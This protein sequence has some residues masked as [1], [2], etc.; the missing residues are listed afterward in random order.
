MHTQIM[1]PSSLAGANVDWARDRAKLWNAAEHA[2]SRRT[3]RVAREFQVTL[4]AELSAEQRLDLARRFSQEL[5]DRYNIA[6]DLAIHAPRAGSD[7]RNFHAHL[8]GTTREVS[9]DGLGR[10]AGMDM[11]AQERLERG[12]MSGSQEF[13]AVRERWASLTNE[14]LRAA[15]VEARVDHRSLAAQ[16][17]DREPIPTIPLAALKI[18]RA[19]QRSEVADR[20]R[21]EYDA[22]VKARQDRSATP[23]PT[24][25]A[26]AP[27]LRRTPKS[28]EDIRREARE[29]WLKMRADQVESPQAQPD[30]EIGRAADDDHSM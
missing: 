13:T 18:E 8:L 2:E 6:V 24:A 11:Q 10:K 5:A 3:A 22:R 23:I 14:A 16:G 21:G 17:I 19:G 27:T 12:L 30:H 20:L 4:P 1:L 29:A 7:P 9:V 28:L 15:H 26:S 25:K